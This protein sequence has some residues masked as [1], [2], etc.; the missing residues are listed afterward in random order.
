STTAIVSDGVFGF[1]RNPIYVSDTI[2]YI[3]LGLILDTWWALIFTPIVIWIMSTGVI[4]REEAYLE[5]KFG[6]DYLEYKRK[7]RRW[8]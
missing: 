7:V 1:S 5:K 3:G 6:N 8:F 2:L 4:A